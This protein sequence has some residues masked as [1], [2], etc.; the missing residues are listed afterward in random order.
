MTIVKKCVKALGDE[1]PKLFCIGTMWIRKWLV[2]LL[3]RLTDGDNLSLRCVG[4]EEKP[5]FIVDIR[6][7]VQ[8]F[9][10]AV[11]AQCGTSDEIVLPPAA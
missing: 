4:C 2:G 1:V 11:D 8:G 3:T 9:L 10:G 5:I 6:E 7:E